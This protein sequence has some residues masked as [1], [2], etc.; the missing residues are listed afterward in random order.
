MKK[1]CLSICICCL[2][3]I[4]VKAQA[5][6]QISLTSAVGTDTQSVSV[7][8]PITNIVYSVTGGTG[9]DFIGLPPGIVGFFNGVGF[10]ITGTASAVGT[11]MYT[12]AS[13]GECTQS[14]ST[15]IITVNS[16][17]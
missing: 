3:F 12:I 13:K 17:E 15:G 16:I 11:Y 10:V 14:T 8:T 5:P 6:C 1:I 9:A 7:N 4:N 2:A